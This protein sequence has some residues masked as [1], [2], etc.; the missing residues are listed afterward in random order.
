[1]KLEDFLAK[2]FTVPGNEVFLICS[3]SANVFEVKFCVFLEM[4]ANLFLFISTSA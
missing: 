4:N 3:M 2:R 1:M